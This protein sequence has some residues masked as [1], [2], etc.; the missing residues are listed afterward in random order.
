MADMWVCAGCAGAAC[1][2]WTILVVAGF[3]PSWA[4]DGLRI[5][6]LSAV[7]VLDGREYVCARKRLRS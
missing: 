1:L 4:L 3:G 6:S 2:L 7:F 5:S